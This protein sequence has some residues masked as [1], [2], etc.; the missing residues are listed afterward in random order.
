MNLPFL[1]LPSAFLQ[2]SVIPSEYRNEETHASLSLTPD[3]FESD[4]DS[5][6]KA[7]STDRQSISGTRGDREVSHDF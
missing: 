2:M 7:H 4:V 1:S 5:R 6:K 3:P